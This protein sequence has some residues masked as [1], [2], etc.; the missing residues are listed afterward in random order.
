MSLAEVLVRYEEEIQSLK[1]ELLD[2]NHRWLQCKIV[3]VKDHSL[4]RNEIVQNS[5][6]LNEVVLMTLYGLL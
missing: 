5:E 6:R 3:L 2:S 1:D 4:R